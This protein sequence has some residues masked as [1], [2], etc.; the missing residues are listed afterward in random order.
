VLSPIHSDLP[1][2]DDRHKSVGV[3]V[4]ELDNLMPL[5]RQLPQRLGFSAF[6]SMA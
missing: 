5:P 2:N 3:Y 1:I 4:L 6:C